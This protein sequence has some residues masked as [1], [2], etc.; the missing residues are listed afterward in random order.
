MSAQVLFTLREQK[1]CQHN[2]DDDV[3]YM[4]VDLEKQLGYNIH[5]TALLFRRELIRCLRPYDGMTPEQWQAL[6]ALWDAEES[7]SPTSLA[8]VTFQDLPSLS[9]M[10]KRME[11]SGWLSRKPDPTDRRSFRV[12]LTRKG[13]Q[14]ESELPPLVLEHFAPILKRLSSSEEKATVG[15][16]QKLRW[17]LGDKSAK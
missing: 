5:R 9:R 17:A 16:L 7:L 1:S 11:E 13:R 14:L 4:A 10:L 15:A 6:N 2:Y 3:W 8:E 12:E